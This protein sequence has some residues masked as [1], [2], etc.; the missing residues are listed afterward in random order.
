MP[1]FN[2]GVITATLTLGICNGLIGCFDEQQTH[3]MVLQADLF[4]SCTSHIVKVSFA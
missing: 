1:N 3:Y 2:G 4:A